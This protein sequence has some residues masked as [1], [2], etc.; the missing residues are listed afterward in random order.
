MIASGG[1]PGYRFSPPT[2]VF[3]SMENLPSQK[4]YC[5]AGPP[6]APEG[7]FN[8]SLCQY[9]SP[10][11]LT[12][13]HFYLGECRAA[14]GVRGGEASFTN[15]SRNKAIFN[16]RQLS[17]FIRVTCDTLKSDDRYVKMTRSGWV[18]LGEYRVLF[19]HNYLRDYYITVG[20]DRALP[21]S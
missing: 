10:V 14:S 6:C 9:D 5:P 20:I 7:T 13:P 15:H 1:I 3:T 12:F 19:L 18:T 2:N 4:C 11:L 17:V 8:V 21:Q 16:H